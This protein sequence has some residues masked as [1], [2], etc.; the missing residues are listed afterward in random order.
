MGFVSLG[1]DFKIMINSVGRSLYSVTLVV[2]SSNSDFVGSSPN[3]S[4]YDVSSNVLFLASS[5]I[6]YPQ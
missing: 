5:S 6:E 2:N 1:S 4:M 3:K